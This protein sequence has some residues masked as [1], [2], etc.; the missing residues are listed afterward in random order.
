MKQMRAGEGGDERGEKE[1]E[2]KDK[3]GM[4]VSC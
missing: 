3:G 4:H 1:G 2:I